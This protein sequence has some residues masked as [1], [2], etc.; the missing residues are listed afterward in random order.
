VESSCFVLLLG[1]GIFWVVFRATQPLTEAGDAFMT[2]LQTGEYR[3]AYEMLSP[4][5]QADIG[6][7]EE[8]QGVLNADVKIRTANHAIRDLQCVF[9]QRRYHFVTAPAMEGTKVSSQR[10]RRL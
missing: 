7:V 6:G 3:A 2:R 9:F 4:A 5:L 1:G 8:L 10:V